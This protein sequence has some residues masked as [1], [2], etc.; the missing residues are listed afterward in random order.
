[1]VGLFQTFRRNSRITIKAEKT[2]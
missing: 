2:P 1:M